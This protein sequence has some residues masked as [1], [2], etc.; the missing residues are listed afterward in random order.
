VRL[1]LNLTLL[2]VPGKPSKTAG[3]ARLN[4]QAA[5]WQPAQMV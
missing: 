1:A 2:G 5:V 3:A 4:R